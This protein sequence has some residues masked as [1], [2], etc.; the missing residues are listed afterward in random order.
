M[1]ARIKRITQLLS[2]A[3]FHPQVRHENGYPEVGAMIKDEVFVWGRVPETA[4]ETEDTDQR[5]AE[6]LVKQ[7]RA[8]AAKV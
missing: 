4:S 6:D 3:G 5:F 1:D 7:A 8:E 2:L